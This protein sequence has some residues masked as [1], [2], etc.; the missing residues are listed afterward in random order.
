[1]D[2][3]KT[4]VLL[5]A[6]GAATVAFYASQASAAGNVIVSVNKGVLRVTGDASDNSIVIEGTESTSVYLVSSGDGTTTIN[7]ALDPYT[8]AVANK[9]V[10]IDMGD[11]ADTLDVHNAVI[12]RTCRI[13]TGT[14]DSSVT[15]DNVVFNM[16]LRL[17]MGDGV[18]SVLLNNTDISEPSKIITGNGVDTVTLNDAEYRGGIK[19]K[20]G[21]DVVVITNSH[22]VDPTGMLSVKTAN[23]LDNV[24]F[25]DAH[26]QGKVLINTGNDDDTVTAGNIVVGVFVKIIGA[27]HTDTLIDNGGHTGAPQF[28]AFE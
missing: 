22:H 14:G 10:L 25:T 23:G 7:G 6:I 18:N 4:A 8:T 2:R 13:A 16:Q 21:D 15:L 11:G 3:K 26:W 9:Q 24:T 20:N 1:M 19:T 28:Y 5:S 12:T 17:T 27:A